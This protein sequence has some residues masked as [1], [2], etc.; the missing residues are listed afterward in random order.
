LSVPVVGQQL[1]ACLALGISLAVAFAWVL[2]SYF[3]VDVV[4]SLIW[5][6]SDGYCETPSQ[7]LG[8]HCFSD[9]SMFLGLGASMDPEGLSPAV[10]FYPPLN[11]LGFFTF[12][13]L[14]IGV[15]HLGAVLLYVALSATC[16]LAPIVWVSRRLPI[17]DQAVIVS[18]AGLLTYPFLATIDRGNNVAFAVPFIFTFVVAL[19]RQRYGIAIVA[20][21]LGSQI[22]PQVGLLVVSFL[23]LRQIKNFVIAV[24]ASVGLF[25]VSF[26]I[27]SVL[28]GGLSPLREFKD[29]ILYTRIFDQIYPLTQ[30]YPV[31]LSFVHLVAVVQEAF[32]FG[33]GHAGMVQFVVY[34]LVGGALAAIVWRGSRLGIAIWFPAILMG[35]LLLP[36]LVFAYYSVGA[37]VV[38]SL[39][40]HQKFATQ[41]AGAPRLVRWLLV[42]ALTASLVPLLIPGGPAEG[43][44]LASEMGIVVSVLP[45]LAS[46]LW[47]AYVITTAIVA[48]RDGPRITIAK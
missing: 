8:V 14:A 18:L 2:A 45:R 6:G 27:Y 23:V 5:P 43:L 20:L 25:L 11:R 1:L 28:P 40:F 37:L 32:G 13:L 10:K 16:L 17:R 22:K 30:M 21:V 3:S 34:L 41:I 26:L 44:M 19:Q 31:N 47:L 33:Q 7:G 9:L 12:Q 48:V 42:G 24:S 38:A 29:W 46:A 15:G 4:G 36:N 39:F 35:V